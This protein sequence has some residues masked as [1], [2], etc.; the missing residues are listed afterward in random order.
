F[1]HI[2]IDESQDLSKVQLKFLNALYLKK[3]Y[4]S[5]MFVADNTQSIYSHSW[6]GKGRPYTT[7][8]YDMSGRAKTLSKNYRTTTEI[9]KAAYGLIE[10]DDNIQNNV[11]FVKPSLIERHGHA[12]IYRYF[13]DDKKQ[14][15]FI[16][17]EIKTLEGEYQLRDICIVAKER[18][19]IENMSLCLEKGNIP[20]EI[21]TEGTSQFETNTVKL[22]TMHSIKGL[23]FKVIFLIHLDENVIP[24]DIH[25]IGDETMLTEERKLMYVGMT[26]ANELLYMS[27][28]RKPSRFI[29]EIQNDYLRMMRDSKIRPFQSIPIQDYLLTDQIVDVNAK[30]EVIRQW[31]LR[32]LTK[33][34]DYPLELITLE[35]PVQQFS[36]RGY[37]DIVV[38][39]E[40]NGKRVP[41]IFAEVKRFASGIDTA[42]EQLKSYMM[43]QPDVRYGV[44][45]DGVDI[46][47]IDR[48]GEAVTDI[49]PCQPQFLPNTKQTRQY[50]DLRHNRTYRYVQDVEDQS[51]VEIIDDENNLMMDVNVDVEVPL[52][53]DV[54]AGIPTAAI[55]NFEDTILLPEDWLI[56]KSLTYALRVTGDS[57]IDAGID[58]GDIIIVHK[59]ESVNN[60]DIVV[61]LID[62]EAT[63]K[64]FML[65]GNTIL[66]LSENP[67]YEP[68]QMNP[69]D[70][71]INGKEI[72]VL[73][74]S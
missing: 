67:N 61:A 35:Y 20:C 45:T 52:I 59:Q 12:P 37:V 53:G 23:E 44:V 24:N 42:L 33:T 27:S 43:A 57:M 40:V 6:L 15:E 69:G 70:V 28:V 48:N 38:S 71:V 25:G 4:S 21:L 16:I 60:G 29:K 74:N 63:V 36:R 34:F 47:I 64:K 51:L 39:I 13:I 62:E 31:L 17:E 65:M 10:H 22:V 26:R 56:R 30:E 3:S 41:Y 46:K 54:A 66:L 18:R 5:I 11:D 2:I 9:S 14:A 8:G 19:L 1:T 7:I 49:P 58:K 55:E 72:G 73:K 50:K 32:E 68:I